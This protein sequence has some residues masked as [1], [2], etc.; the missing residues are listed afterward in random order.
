MGEAARRTVHA[1]YQPEGRA[2]ELVETLQHTVDR[3][4][5][6]LPPAEHVLQEWA[7]R[8]SH[9]CEG[10]SQ[11]AQEWEAR[12]E[13][14]RQALAHYEEQLAR[15]V[16]EKDRLIAQHRR[17]IQHQK[18]MIERTQELIEEIMQ[19]RVMRLMTSTQ[20]WLRAI[21]GRPDES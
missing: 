14:L 3:H 1:R 15:T 10:M 13:S 11:D 5:R 19:G 9:Y 20:R 18:R 7:V 8:M 16:R 12:A 4:G 17:T 2:S 6:P 21:M